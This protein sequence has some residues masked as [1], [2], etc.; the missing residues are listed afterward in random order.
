MQKSENV[1]NKEELHPDLDCLP[2]I[3]LLAA[4]RRKHLGPEL[5]IMLTS[6][7]AA[8]LGAPC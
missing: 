4:A 2:G 7:Q 8:A 6:Q 1:R 3:C 5:G